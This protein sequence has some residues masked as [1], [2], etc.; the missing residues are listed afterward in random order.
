M[1]LDE[2]VSQLRSAYGDALRAAVLYGSAV[3]GERL[4]KRSDYNVLVIVREIPLDRL[5]ALS[6]VA[7]AWKAAGNPPP[8]T[9]TEAEWR[10]SA[11]VF[12]ME[13]ADILERHRVLWAAGDADPLAGITVDRG[14]LRLQT[15]RESLAVLLRLRQAI[16]VAGTDPAEQGRLLE[17]S[18]S[19]LMI[20]FRAVLRLAG[21]TPPTDY[22]ELARE[23]AGVVGIS[24]DPLEDVVRHARGERKV[25]K[26][27]AG[28][29][30]RAYYGAMEAVAR[31]VD[32]LPP[33]R[34]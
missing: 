32:A 22:L 24:P 28:A 9:L 23:G 33:S 2:L 16:L 27:G 11:D 25:P 12:P 20:V 13:Y 4:G 34:T 10:S 1:T 15:E 30:L 26:E 3:A 17:A 19:S 7:R 31:H 5:A 18:L 29:V 14:D 6:A 21:R 8:M